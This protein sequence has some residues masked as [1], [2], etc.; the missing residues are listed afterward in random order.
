M[1]ESRGSMENLDFHIVL[2]ISPPCR[3]SQT[4]KTFITLGS[5]ALH[6]ART[7]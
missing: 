5:G 3:V 4:S 1:Y 6:F 7:A 2:R